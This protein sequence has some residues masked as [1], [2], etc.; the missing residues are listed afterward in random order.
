MVS[1][2]TAIIAQITNI[3]A[4]ISWF[5]IAV[6][7]NGKIRCKG[8]FRSSCYIPYVISGVAVTVFFMYFF[9]KDGPATKFFSL[10]GLENVSWFASTKYALAFLIIVYVWQQVGFYMVI[11]IGG[12]QEVPAELYEAAK[13]DGAGAWQRLIKITVPLIKNTTYLLSLIHIC[14]TTIRSFTA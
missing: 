11:F 12:L 3:A 4:E 9:I 13:V 5:A 7:L 8:F 6:L 14:K 10:L 2:T 1:S